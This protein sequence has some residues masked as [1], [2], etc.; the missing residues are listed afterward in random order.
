MVLNPALSPCVF[1]PPEYLSNVYAL[2][3]GDHNGLNNGVF[4]LKVHP[5]SVDLLTKTINYPLAHPEDDLGWFGEQAAMAHV[6]NATETRHESAGTSSGIAW[7][8]RVWFNNYEFEHGFEG[9]PGSFLVHFAGLA[10]TRLQHMAN[11]LDEL[12]VNQAKWEI[13]LE[14]TSYKDSILE[15]WRKYAE[16]LNGRTR[17]F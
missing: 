16:S 3:T 10:E 11:W 8:P 7:V 9:K 14:E 2:V 13:P 1:L 12:S 17:A 5:S 6:I 15:F 4:Y